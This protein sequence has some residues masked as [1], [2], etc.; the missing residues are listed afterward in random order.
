MP[1]L[2]QWGEPRPLNQS[3]FGQTGEN[4]PSRDKLCLGGG[5]HADGACHC[6]SCVHRI[7]IDRGRTRL[8][9]VPPADGRRTSSLTSRGRLDAPLL[10]C[11]PQAVRTSAPI[12]PRISKPRKATR[13]TSLLSG[14]AFAP[15][16]A[17]MARKI[18]NAAFMAEG[19]ICA[20]GC[21][22]LL[23]GI[24][25]GDPMCA[26]ATPAV[27]HR[28]IGQWCRANPL[29][30]SY[31]CASPCKAIAAAGARELKATP[32]IHRPGGWDPPP[33]WWPQK[34]TPWTPLGDDGSAARPGGCPRPQTPW[35][36]SG[37]SRGSPPGVGRPQWGACRCRRLRVWL[38]PASR[39]RLRSRQHRSPGRE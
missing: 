36:V 23:D 5:P 29:H 33:H 15:P 3:P 28:S 13:G 39:K 35:G 7:R 22:P 34:L 11:G 26:P 1:A 21:L 4:S 20:S 16:P 19:R 6:C 30:L 27:I 32:P 8:V 24:L 25:A 2:P 31:S 18:P 14:P 38:A 9:R 37:K 12:I 10:T 17:M